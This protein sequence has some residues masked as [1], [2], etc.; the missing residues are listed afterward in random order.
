MRL[1]LALLIFVLT[2]LV[3]INMAQEDTVTLDLS[4]ILDRI[5]QS[6]NVSV[7]CLEQVNNLDNFQSE[8]TLTVDNTCPPYEDGGSTGTLAD[9][10]SGQ[11]GGTNETYTVQSG[12]RLADIADEFGVSV[13][14]IQS[15][16]NIT[17]PDFIFIGQELVI[18]EDC[19]NT[20]TG[21]AIARGNCDG[22]RNAGRELEGLFYTVQSGDILDF[23]ACDFNVSTA[24]LIENNTSLQDRR[25]PLSVG[26]RLS[27]DSE[28]AGWDGPYNSGVLNG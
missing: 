18:N 7:D 24:C 6:F 4:D 10:V 11:G 17:D 20:T 19:E 27:I 1:K 9:A 25:E 15:A 12:D 28:C 26:Q 21:S 22:D 8:G 13:A 14:C 16:N 2:M 5:A 23:I 3:N